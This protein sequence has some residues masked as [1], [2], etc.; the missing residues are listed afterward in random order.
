MP[1]V[2]DELITVLSFRGDAEGITNT[3]TRLRGMS[4]DINAAARGLGILGGAITAIGG[5]SLGLGISWETAFTDV[6][7]T[8]NGTDEELAR[9]ESRLREMAKTEVPLPV[10]G[11]AAITASAGQL[12]IA[13]PVIDDFTKVIAQLGSTTNLA[14][15]QGAQDLARFANITQMSQDDF[16]RLGA[17]IVHLGNNFATTEAEIVEMSLRLAGAGNLVGLTE[18]QILSLAT[19]LTS[20]GIN[21]EAGGTAFS[22][23]FTEMQKA[24]QTGGA[25][26]HLFNQLL[27][28][29]FAALFEAAPDRAVVE[30]IA[31]LQGMI[32]SGGSVHEV[33]EELGFDS[34]RIRDSLLRS[35][36]AG[37]LMADALRQGTQAWEENI[38]L[39]READLRYGTA[40]SRIQF[41]KN[42]A[43]DLGITAG[44]ILAP[45]L[46]EVLNVIQPLTEGLAEFAEEHPRVTQAVFIFGGVLLGLSA[47][48]FGVA[49]ALRV[50]AFSLAPVTGLVNLLRGSTL[51]LRIQLLLLAVQ[52]RITAAAT[53]LLTAAQT[54]LAAVTN[55]LTLANARAVIG[56]IAYRAAMIAG[57]V[58]TGIATAAQLAL[59]LAMSLNPITLIIIGIIALIAALIAVGYA[60]YRFRDAILDG[61]GAAW[62]WAKDNWPLLLGILTGPFGLAVYAIIRY[63]DQIIGIITG[64]IDRIKSIWPDSLGGFFGGVGSILGFAQGGV[65]PGPLGQPQ[66]AIVHGGEIVLS[67]DMVRQMRVGA[68]A[69]TPLTAD[70]IDSG[71]GGELFP[72]DMIRRLAIGPGGLAPSLPSALG[73]GG[74]GGLVIGD[75]NVT[76]TVADGSDGRTIGDA[77]AQRLRDEVEDLVADFDGP[78]LR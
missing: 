76:V 13:T 60:I 72:A 70:R 66:A 9:I 65:V 22:R 5:L 53:W 54:G 30:F 19:G 18:A 64:L 31:A 6:L 52:Q 49:A 24:V 12:G 21:A 50:L 40:A 28:K 4:D 10:E 47:A 17:A 69:L 11:L 3:R 44:E 74:G 78:V 15:E 57:A 67:Q 43:K 56:L 20:V 45:R 29:D 23:V 71:R 7:K 32:D 58:A 61:L 51:L 39:T 59:N 2:I 63:K 37:D 38:A 55:A 14:T 33:L 36:G 27:G 26:L 35:A 75:I 1:T 16:G 77:I 8:V 25:E 34:V 62:D 46:I 42:Q 41:A 48:L 68:N 73:A